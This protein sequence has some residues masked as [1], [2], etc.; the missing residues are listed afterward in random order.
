MDGYTVLS[1]MEALLKKVHKDRVRSLIRKFNVGLNIYIFKICVF[2]RLVFYKRQPVLSN[3]TSTYH[4]K[5]IN[6]D[7]Y[8]L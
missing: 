6:V 3:Y 4:V 8:V 7:A 1:I 5:N 2:F